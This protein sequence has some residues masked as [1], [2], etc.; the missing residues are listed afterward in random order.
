VLAIRA[1]VG[2]WGNTGGRISGHY[3]GREAYS[4]VQGGGK[5]REPGIRTAGRASTAY[6]SN[7]L[8]PHA[9]LPALPG[10]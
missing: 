7:L 6:R 8:R 9:P 4:T 3:H 2:H 1:L 10:F 5:R